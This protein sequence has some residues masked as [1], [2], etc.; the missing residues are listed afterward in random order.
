MR[1]LSPADRKMF[2]VAHDLVD[3]SP[4]S[5]E[6]RQGV[7]VL[8]DALPS[9]GTRGQFT[10]MTGFDPT[11]AQQRVA[12]FDPWFFFNL[13]KIDPDTFQD[14]T[15]FYRMLNSVGQEFDLRRKVD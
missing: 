5:T 14:K 11:Y 4:Y 12:S 15:K 13:E 9:V 8:R 10:R 6:I 3:N 1:Y 2:Q 7:K